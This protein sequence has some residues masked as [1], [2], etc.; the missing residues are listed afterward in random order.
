FEG[1]SVEL[2]KSALDNYK[3]N[4]VWKTNPAMDEADFVRIQDIME[5]AGELKARVPFDVLVDN[6]IANK[7]T[8]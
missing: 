7:V 5:N 1:T 2:I 4:D 3:A 8:K 6:S